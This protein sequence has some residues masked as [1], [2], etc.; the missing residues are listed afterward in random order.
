M[1]EFRKIFDKEMTGQYKTAVLKN[2]GRDGNF[3]C[4][5][6]AVHYGASALASALQHAPPIPVR[7]I[8]QSVLLNCCTAHPHS[9]MCPVP[10]VQ[11]ATIA[12]H[13]RATPPLP[14]SLFPM[15]QSEGLCWVALLCLSHIH[16]QVPPWVLLSPCPS[17]EHQEGERRRKEAIGRKRKVAIL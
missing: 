2:W 13:R 9:R 16:T 17:P 7:G 1:G 12:P 8:S 10:L 14:I 4:H 3:R 6:R 5:Q 15:A 11:S